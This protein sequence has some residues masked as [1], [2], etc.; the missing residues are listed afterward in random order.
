MTDTISQDNVKPFKWVGTRPVRPDGVP[1][2]TGLAQYG[3]DVD[4]PGMMVGRILRSPHAHAKIK[5]ID[6][7]AARKMPGVVDVLTGGQLADDKIGNLIC[8]WMIHAKDG[9]PM[10]A[11]AHPAL[12]Q[13]LAL[14]LLPARLPTQPRH[15]VAS[16][17]HLAHEPVRISR[18]VTRRRGGPPND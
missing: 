1:K 3:A 6:V 10:K 14:A 5:S 7:S 13:G 2:V 15:D 11:G 17:S 16:P 9:S 4:M 18:S 8:G 12:A